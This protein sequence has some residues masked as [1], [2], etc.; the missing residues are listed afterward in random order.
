MV[1]LYSRVVVANPYLA[2]TVLAGLARLAVCTSP[3]SAAGRVP[4]PLR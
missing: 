4:V 3:G 1:R 2:G